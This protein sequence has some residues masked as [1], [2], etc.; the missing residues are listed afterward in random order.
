MSC[1][2]TQ[3]YGALTPWKTCM[4]LSILPS[5]YPQPMK[6]QAI[7]LSETAQHVTSESRIKEFPSIFDRKVKPTEGEQFH[8]A[9]VD[10]AKLFCVNTHRTIPYAYRASGASELRR[11][12]NKITCTIPTEWC[13]P[14]VVAHKKG[15]DDIRMCI[16]LSHLSQNVS[17]P[18]LPHQLKWKPTSQQK[19]H[20]YLPN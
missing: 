13:A 10:D 18:N 11:T 3:V 14:I 1:T 15:T 5:T 4:A 17:V 19:R 12:R 16:D 20:R 7:T 6:V 9:L 2:Y 8:I